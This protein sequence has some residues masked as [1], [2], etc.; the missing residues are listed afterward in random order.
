MVFN[1]LPPNTVKAGGVAE[2][3]TIDNFR[4]KLTGSGT[5]VSPAGRNGTSGAATG[6]GTWRLYSP[7]DVPVANGTYEVTDVLSWQ[8]AGSFTP[9]VL[10]DNIGPGGAERKRVSRKRKS[11]GSG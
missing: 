7:N 4:L 10:D 1:T 2:A 3:R 5:F 11:E 9:G 8:F 6:G